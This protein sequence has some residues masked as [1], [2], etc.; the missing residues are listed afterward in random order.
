MHAF[1]ASAD[2]IEETAGD[3]TLMPRAMD[4]YRLAAFSEAVRSEIYT[5]AAT[6][7]Q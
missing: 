4:N 7:F 1:R 5:E 2:D 6:E 3:L